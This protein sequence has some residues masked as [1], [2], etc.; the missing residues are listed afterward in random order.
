[1]LKPI[2][3]PTLLI[4]LLTNKTVVI[5][6]TKGLEDPD[7]PFEMQR[8]ATWCHDLNELDKSMSIFLLIKI[9]WTNTII[10][11]T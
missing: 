5:V 10:L 9:L 8:L 11:N 6:K 3:Q 1:M 7:V 4:F 2:Y